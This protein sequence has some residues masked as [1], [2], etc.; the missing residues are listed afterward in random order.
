MQ[1]QWLQPSAGK[2]DKKRISSPLGP[3]KALG[4]FWM[5]VIVRTVRQFIE[6]GVRACFITSA[7][8]GIVT[9]IGSLEH[10]DYSSQTY[11]LRQNNKNNRYKNNIYSRLSLVNWLSGTSVPLRLVTRRELQRRRVDTAVAT[12]LLWGQD[13]R[14][15][16]ETSSA[17]TR[18]KGDCHLVAVTSSH[19]GTQYRERETLEHRF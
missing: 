13:S 19:A 3:N 17:I 6:V 8:N 10:R 1:C 5:W 4:S 14:I 16:R 18:Y 15:H 11:R 12:F 7:Q 9:T 2:Q